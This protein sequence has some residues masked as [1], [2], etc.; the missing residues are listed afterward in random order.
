MK[1]HNTNHSACRRLKAF[2]LIEL[3]VVIAIIAILIALLLPAVQQAREAARRSQ[4]KNSLKQIGLAI[5]NYHDAAK[6]FPYATDSVG[7]MSGTGIPAIK[8]Q[9]GWVMLLPYLDQAPLYKTLDLGAAM[10]RWV[11][12]S[13]VP[14]AKGGPTA[15][16]GAASNKRLEGLICPSDNGRDIYPGF[17]GTYGCVAGV[18]SYKSTYGFSV[19]TGQP[20]GLW[21]NEGT[22]TRAM[23]GAS[24]NSSMR[25]LKDGSSNTVAFAETT[26]NVYDGI[27]QSWACGQHVGNGVMFATLNGQ[28]R[29]ND[30]DCC[31]WGPGTP[32]SIKNPVGTLGEWG[33]PG[34]LHNGG[35]HAAMADGAVR[36]IN[37]AING[38]T[39][40]RLG[41]IADG[42]VLGEF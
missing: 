26:L 19:A 12:G 28:R 20:Y 37:Q 33:T 4:C 40:T 34:S 11:A 17:D 13:A 14:L 9:T 15:A 5:Q 1:I 21:S 36:F 24:S 27:T 3:L 30:W 31:G 42:Q 35:M 32:W 22:T 2:T 29:I 39:R 38:T 10:G 41:Y 23:F 6:V 16:N 8:N 18:A 7:T 25:D